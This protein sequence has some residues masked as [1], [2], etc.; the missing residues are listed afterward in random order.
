MHLF[1]E[2]VKTRKQFKKKKEQKQTTKKE[3]VCKKQKLGKLE[4]FNSSGNSDKHQC[5]LPP[6]SFQLS[7]WV[8]LA[9][10]F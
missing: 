7:N 6:S 4:V 3:D 10:G 9:K 1:K 8:F 2:T 5:L